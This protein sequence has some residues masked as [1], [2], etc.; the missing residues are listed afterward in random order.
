MGKR[1][2]KAI[3]GI[4]ITMILITV[5]GL[6]V[7]EYT[8]PGYRMSIAIHGFAKIS[9]NIYVDQNWHGDTN[10]LLRLIWEARDRVRN[11]FGELMSQPTV[12]ICDD[13]QKLARL[14]SD[15]DTFTVMLFQTNSYIS[16]SSEWLNVDVLA[17]EFTHAE[18]HT[19][20][21][22]GGISFDQ[23]IPTW[24]DE[25]LAIQNDYREQYSYQTWLNIT[26]N[27]TIVPSIAQYDTA[28][29]FYAG[30][31]EDRRKRYCLAGHEIGTW[32]E[33]NGKEAM[34]TLLNKISKGAEF[35]SLNFRHQAE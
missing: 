21:F 17:H 27:G 7:F 11:F 31:V 24:F 29:K 15:H 1:K 19:R 33:H 20:I 13:K 18:V 2:K 25:G 5:A 35:S 4:V 3:I 12:I 9:D 22:R 28:D 23:P 16:V 8:I 26:D 10:Q 32:I 30:D 6:C 14:G 34:I